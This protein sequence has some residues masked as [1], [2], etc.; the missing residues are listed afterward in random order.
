MATGEVERSAEL[1]IDADEPPDP[2]LEATNDLA[3]ALRANVATWMTTLDRIDQFR[4]DRAAGVGY[5]EMVAREADPTVILKLAEG[6]ERLAIAGARFRRAVVRMMLDAGVS[7]AQIAKR[8]GV[9]RQRVAALLSEDPQPSP[10]T[11]RETAE[12]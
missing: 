6:Q 4:A 9:S 3:K 2:L 1:H 5:R 12:L 7:Q 11:G 10:G 8:F